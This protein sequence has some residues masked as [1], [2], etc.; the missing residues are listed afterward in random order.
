M[1]LADCQKKF[2]IIDQDILLR[3]FH[4]VGFLNSTVNWVQYYPLNLT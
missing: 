2:G 1:I 3:E 4:V